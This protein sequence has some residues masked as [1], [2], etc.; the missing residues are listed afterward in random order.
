MYN[1]NDGASEAPLYLVP[2]SEGTGKRLVRRPHPPPTTA[3]LPDDFDAITVTRGSTTIYDDPGN[4][5]L[6]IDYDAVTIAATAAL[7]RPLPIHAPVPLSPT[8]NPV[9]PLR[10]RR[11]ASP[12]HSFAGPDPR[13]AGG[14][15]GLMPHSKG[16]GH[17]KARSVAG[18]R[19][20]RRSLGSGNYPPAA[21]PPFP[22]G[23]GPAAGRNDLV[24]KKVLEDGPERTISFWREDVAKSSSEAGDG[25]GDIRSDLD[26]HAGRRRRVD[27]V[28]QATGSARSKGH[29]S[30]ESADLTEAGAPE[31]PFYRWRSV[32]G[33]STT[34]LANAPAINTTPQPSTPQKSQRRM[35]PSLSVAPKATEYSA[36]IS[37]ATSHTKVT[38]SAQIESVLSSCQPSLLH[39]LPILEELGVRRSEHMTALAR[40][41]EETRDRE[42][43]EE[44]LKKGITVVE[45]A[46]LIDKLQTL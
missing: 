38:S 35:P 39:L 11:P 40:M 31:I 23:K 3:P 5:A 21:A 2:N 10:Q 30:R 33:R 34:P 27:S 29:R 9:S 37:E 26:S 18:D 44:A 24:E 7:E 6:G 32:S 13:S 25:D 17:G 12:S 43:K 8:R 28:A 15:D 36:S 19:S 1:L 46:I 16:L 41:R 20:A 14:G 4:S 22:P 42:V 45:W